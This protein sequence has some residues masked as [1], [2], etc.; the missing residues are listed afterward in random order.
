[1]Q[2]NMDKKL[3]SGIIIALFVFSFLIVPQ[4]V[5]CQEATP[6]DE[7]TNEPT[8]T[9][10]AEQGSSL[11]LLLIGG[12]IAAV[13]VIAVV[14]AFV[15]VKKR[16][17]NEKSLRKFS[18]RNFE[19]WVIKRFNGKPSDP[20]SGVNGFTAGGQPL[21]IKQSDHVSLAEVEDFVK[22]LVKGKTQKGTIVALSFDN[23]AIEGKVT[24]M[25]NEIDLQMFRINE[26]LNK[27]Y[28]AKIESLARSPVTF[29]APLA[30]LVE[31]QLIETE[32]KSFENL[33][34]I[35]QREGIKPRV[36]VSNSNTKVAEQV[37]KMLD[38]LHYNY[39]VGDK[40]ETT[41]PISETKFGLMRDCDCAI[42]NIAAVEQERRYSGIYILNSNVTSEINAAYLKYNTQVVLLV[43]RKVELPSNLKGL[44]R[45]EY[46]TDDLTFNAAMELEKALIEFK[47]V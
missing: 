44:K 15:V 28:A 17:V 25:D 16:K 5:S 26:L 41:V 21:L 20:S 23:D 19:E 32:T 12:I 4:I 9:E 47:K 6:S 24:A 1:M 14:S 29:E 3:L 10:T 42:I 35:P 13:A 39:A 37:K 33:P 36:F 7:E 22:L 38:F 2:K 8:P 27:H 34:I 31:D 18:S 40:E 11:D 46:D 30:G 45:I 43:E